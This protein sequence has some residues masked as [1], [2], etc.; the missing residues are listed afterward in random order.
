MVEVKFK[1]KFKELISLSE[2]K[3]TKGLEDMLI[4]K[5]GNRLSITPIDKK[6]FEKIIEISKK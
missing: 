6:H 2:I 5:K 1:K 3:E 4:L